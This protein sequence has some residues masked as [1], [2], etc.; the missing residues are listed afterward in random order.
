MWEP[1]Q[2]SFCPGCVLERRADAVP[3]FVRPNILAADVI[4]WHIVG[5]WINHCKVTV[6]NGCFGVIGDYW[7]QVNS[8]QITEEKRIWLLCVLVYYIATK[9]IPTWCLGELRFFIHVFCISPFF[10]FF[11]LHFCPSFLGISFF[12]FRPAWPQGRIRPLWADCLLMNM[13]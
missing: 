1:F 11:S 8:V 7:E 12:F 4:M 3:R 9:K 10:Q 6:R 5:A 2:C 13:F